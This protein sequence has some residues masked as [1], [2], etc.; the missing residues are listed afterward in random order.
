[1]E[2][3]PEIEDV[4]GFVQEL[5]GCQDDAILLSTCLF[6]LRTSLRLCIRQRLA[7]VAP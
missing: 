3:S 6:H 5:A 2:D 7:E 1:M 4:D